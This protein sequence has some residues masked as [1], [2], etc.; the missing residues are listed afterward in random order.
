[1]HLL[2]TRRRAHASRR[3]HQLRG[4]AAAARRRRIAVHPRYGDANLFVQLTPRKT[5][6]PFLLI[7]SVE[8]SAVEGCAVETYCST[9][10][11]LRKHTENVVE[12]R[13][14]WVGLYALQTC[15]QN[16]VYALCAYATCKCTSASERSNDYT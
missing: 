6:P 9:T 8:G 3:G 13:R 15:A 10:V 4:T 14:A 1:M 5:V 16:Q 12:V 11:R 2:T 7:V